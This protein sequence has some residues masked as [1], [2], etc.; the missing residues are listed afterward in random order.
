MLLVKLTMVSMVQLV[1]T[2]H[3]SLVVTCSVSHITRLV[4]GSLVVKSVKQSLV[5][6]CVDY[7][8]SQASA[9]LEVNVST[10]S[11]GRKHLMSVVQVKVG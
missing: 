10:M 5:T 7:V 9:A 6:W 8:I 11:M 2:S 1:S 3:K 4:S